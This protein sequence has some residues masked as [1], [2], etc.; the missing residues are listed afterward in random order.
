MN[1]I[2]SNDI[3]ISIRNNGSIFVQ[4]VGAFYMFRRLKFR[5]GGN[6][7]RFLDKG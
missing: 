5:I 2:H 3:I 6:R 1:Y 7:A 4:C